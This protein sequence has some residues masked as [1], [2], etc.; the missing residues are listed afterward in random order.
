MSTYG[1]K[2]ACLALVVRWEDQLRVV[3]GRAI[4]QGA[5]DVQV[6]VDDMTKEDDCKSV[7]AATRET[8]PL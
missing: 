8:R 4:T 6:L 2:G 1:Q 3:A 7:I 5:S